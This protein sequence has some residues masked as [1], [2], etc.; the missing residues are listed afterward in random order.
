MLPRGCFKG[1][2]GLLCTMEREK[3]AGQIHGYSAWL[4]WRKRSEQA[5]HW[6]YLQIQSKTTMRSEGWLT[7]Q[8]NCPWNHRILWSWHRK[9][10]WCYI[11]VGFVWSFD[12]WFC[13]KSYLS[14]FCHKMYSSWINPS[15]RSQSYWQDI[16]CHHKNWQSVSLDEI[17]NDVDEEGGG[18]ETTPMLG[19][20]LTK[21]MFNFV[22]QCMQRLLWSLWRS[23][24]FKQAK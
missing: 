14:Q 6:W 21:L 11:A 13:P 12:D 4:A 24:R 7:G 5:L 3:D 17:P 16:D 22:T 15:W 8:W 2:Y 18:Q 9:N 10:S 20:L 19:T 23:L 1:W